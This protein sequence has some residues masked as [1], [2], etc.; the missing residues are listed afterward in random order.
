[1]G[2]KT[3][4]TNAKHNLVEFYDTEHL[5]NVT[6]LL[7]GEYTSVTYV[8]FKH[9]NEPDKWEREMLRRF[10]PQKFGV[11]VHFLEI[12][13]HSITCAVEAFGDLVSSGE[14]YDFD[15][16]GGSSVFIAAVGVLCANDR[17]KRLALHECDVAKGSCRFLY[18]A[19][20]VLPRRKE[21]I[22]LSVAEVLS[23]REITVLDPGLPVYVSLADA[24][25]RREI[26][27]LWSVVR[28]NFKAWN[29]YGMTPTAYEFQGAFGVWVE[30]QLSPDQWRTVE[31]LLYAMEKKGILTSL[32]VETNA[33]GARTSFLLQ[34]R[35]KDW[36]LYA[37]GGNLL[38]MLT[39]L[40][41][42]ES[43]ACNDCCTGIKLD[44]DK[45]WEDLGS[46]PYN[47]IDVVAVRG[48]IPYFISCKNKSAT[49]ENLYEIMTMT[50]HY[51]GAYAVPVMVA[52]V[53]SK[54]GVL[55]RAKEMGVV[56][57]DAVEELSADMLSRKMKEALKTRAGQ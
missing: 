53:G 37:K 5:E 24:A 16:T 52:T 47:E 4:D 23:L 40:A 17:E 38:E 19:D 39:A 8:Y 46:N 29:I 26:D 44:W 6:S 55:A 48:H 57:I 7:L 18:P 2:K 45:R 31:P 27:R 12:S 43:D 9:A 10:I 22:T 32:A 3:F 1:M 15:I 49:N 42:V 34:V 51:G 25:L 30:K 14:R 11:P 41:V 33:W 54:D 20:A 13:E 28:E 35:Q 21:P 36:F 56:L 50:R